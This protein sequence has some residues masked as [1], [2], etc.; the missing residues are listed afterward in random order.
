MTIG[1]GITGLGMATK[2]HMTSLRELEAAGRAKIVG[3]FAPSPER[4]RACTSCW[5]T[6]K[7]KLCSRP[8]K[9][10]L[11]QGTCDIY[12]PSLPLCQRRTSGGE[13][14]RK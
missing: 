12:D 3:G 14:R 13:Q 6:P 8:G 1:V 11:A 4:R 10:R 2:P 7:P 9:R 5:K